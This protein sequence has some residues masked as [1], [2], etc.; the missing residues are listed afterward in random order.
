MNKIIVRAVHIPS[1]ED[2]GLITGAARMTQVRGLMPDGVELDKNLLGR[3]LQMGHTSCLEHA[4]FAVVVEGATRVFLAQITRHRLASYTSASQQYQLHNGFDYLM[5]PFENPGLKE[6]YELHMQ[7]ADELYNQ[8]EE[9]MGRDWA[10]Y[11]L[12]NACRNT[13]LMKT[14]LRNWFTAVFP[15][16]LCKRNTPETLLVLNKALTLAAENGMESLCKYAGPACVT[17]GACDQGKMCCGKP[18]AQWEELL[19]QE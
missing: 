13:L 12:P 14:N 4:D 17:K 19:C 2:L 16:R 5:L 15:Q 7:Q 10:R 11:V 6:T 3:L 8:V 18:Y 1:N 9:E